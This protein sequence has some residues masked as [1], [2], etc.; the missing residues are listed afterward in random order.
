MS[1]SISEAEV[2]EKLS[3][4]FSRTVRRKAF[5]RSTWAIFHSS[6]PQ[7]QCSTPSGSGSRKSVRA[8]PNSFE[9][10]IGNLWGAARKDSSLMKARRHIHHAEHHHVLAVQLPD[11]EDVELDSVTKLGHRRRCSRRWWCLW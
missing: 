5:W 7:R 3:T 11:I 10:L 8:K 4:N 9:G 2:A 6:V 1:R